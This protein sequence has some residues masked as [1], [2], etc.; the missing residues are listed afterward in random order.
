MSDNKI[1]VSINGD[2]IELKDD[3]YQYVSIP[4][5]E[6]QELKDTIDAKIHGKYYHLRE[7]IKRTDPI[8]L[9]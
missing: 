2:N 6:W 4:I 7:L 9:D 3:T 8:K 5:G 1:Q